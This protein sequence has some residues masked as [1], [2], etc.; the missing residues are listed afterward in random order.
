MTP[1]TVPPEI[2][3]FLDDVADSFI[4]IELIKFF[5]RNRRLLGAIEDI[6]VSIGRDKKTTAKAIPH[7]LSAGIIKATRNG[8]AALWSYD[9]DPEITQRIDAFLAYY[10]TE[11]GRR[12]VVHRLLEGEV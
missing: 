6:A 7:L 2:E 12:A 10:T 9:P 1:R 11:R 8:S 4:K 5:R 3:T